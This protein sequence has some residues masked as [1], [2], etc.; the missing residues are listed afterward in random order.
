MERRARWLA[1]RNLGRALSVRGG[2]RDRLVDAQRRGR[3][4]RR[5][6]TADR[7]EQADH[8]SHDRRRARLGLLRRVYKLKLLKGDRVTIRTR[9]LAGDTAP[10]QS[11]FLP[12]TTDEDRSVAGARAVS[13]GAHVAA[14]RRHAGRPD[15][16]PRPKRHLRPRHEQPLLRRARLLSRRP[17]VGLQIH[18]NRAAPA[19]A[20]VCFGPEDTRCRH[21]GDFRRVRE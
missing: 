5:E 3:T 17:A 7:A 14:A 1:A 8:G 6:R 15:L 21:E 2:G 11:L 19:A 20:R 10:C 18:R 12:G 13:A 4:G 16:D 9:A